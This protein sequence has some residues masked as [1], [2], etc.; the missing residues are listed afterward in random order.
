L[1]DVFNAT[2]L[3]STVALSS[4]LLLAAMGGFMS[5]R[6]GVINIALEGK[7]L[8]SACVTAIVGG[9]T[10]NAAFGLLAG[11]ASAILLSWLHWMLTQPF[12]MDQIVSG[13]AIN[14]VAFGA[15]NYLDKRFANPQAEAPP[16]TLP[17]GLYYAL[18]FALPIV[19]ALT[20][21]RTR[22]G[23]RLL[24]VGNDP[25]KAR[26]AGVSPA[27]IRLQAL[28]FTG[29]LTGLS[30]A[31]IFTNAKWFT[32]GMTAGS[33]FIALAALIIGGWRPIPAAIACVVFGFFDALQYQV[34]GTGFLG[35]RLPPEFWS[36]LPFLATLVAMAG[37]LG[38]SRAPAG[39]GKA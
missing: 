31:L 38:R 37:L 36:S 21:K 28:T 27:A 25:E 18:A 9:A 33:G 16:P 12:R 2:L 32:D 30:G 20:A 22:Y 24:A 5:E 35:A 17:L 8:S 10:R 39:L 13:M 6:S 7:M 1:G 15:T 3:L 34:Q 11:V 19:L 26:Q 29:V 4:K 23:L 14:A